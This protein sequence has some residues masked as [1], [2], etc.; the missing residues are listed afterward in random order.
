MGA[1]L[2]R[3]ERETMVKLIQIPMPENRTPDSNPSFLK[4][5]YDLHAAAE[6][7]SAARRKERRTGDKLAQVPGVRI[8]N[9]LDRFKEITNRT[10]PDKRERGMQALKRVMFGKFITKVED[11]PQ[12]YWK[13]QEGILRERGQQGDYDHFSTEEKNTWKK[14]ISEGLL[15][16]QRASLEQWIDY[17]A[18]DDSSY[19]PD[20]LKYWVF[21]SVTGLSEYDKEKREFPK[22]SKGTVKAFP[23]IN[24]EA[25]S[26][27]I[28]MVK[29]QH[30]GQAITF[31]QF[32]HDLT[33]EQKE[34]FQKYLTQENFAKL[35]GF[36]NE[37]IKPIPEHLL[38][39]TEGRW[40]KY[41]QHSDHMQLVQSIRGQ[42]TGWCT[43][44]ENTAR[45]QLQG[46]DFHV[47]YT[48]DDWGRPT[49]PRIAIRMEQGHIAEVRG[50][51]QK[52]NLDPFM[53]EV[54][55][56]KLD[57][58]PDKDR[59]LKKEHDMRRLT[60]IDKRMKQGE[61]LGKD[62]IVFLYELD[63]PI[64]GFGYVADPRIKELLDARNPQEDMLV[65]F[66]CTSDQV[67][68]T[69]D[70]IDHHTKAYVGKL[71]PGIF[72][73][74]KHIEHIYTSFPE[75][76]V[77]REEFEINE[78]ASAQIKTELEKAGF[79]IEAGAREMLDNPDFPQVTRRENISLVRLRLRDIG[80]SYRAR[81]IDEVYKLA[82]TIGLDFCPAALAP[83]Y[84][85]T[86]RDIPNMKSI[87]FA[88]EPING[89]HGKYIFSISDTPESWLESDNAFNL[90]S[91]REFIFTLPNH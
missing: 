81:G 2:G 76:K 23:D 46:G 44:G 63:A 71:A 54:L 6:V 79:L 68:T 17:L 18:S 60:E 37:L 51:A 13:S 80:V 53:G 58:F 39:V 33:D 30:Q 66:E 48:L 32:E 22:R 27:V 24:H 90:F 84:R 47:Y 77:Q 86:R 50:I 83:Q 43:A 56:K 10:D 62:D 21:R 85:L 72:D 45:T 70:Q 42:G 7:A 82:R 26:Y 88:M 75:G 11:I 73:S 3:L 28:D 20:H 12:S 55:E 89:R 31:E 8:Q 67:A 49:I 40:V 34:D 29:K 35:Y 41:E 38:P 91:E 5:R 1:R 16:D 78:K 15:D 69:P 4:K 14:E 19:L 9:Y 87:F 57:E 65:V 36:A 64:E 59:Y 52:Q 61:A 25:L 74:L